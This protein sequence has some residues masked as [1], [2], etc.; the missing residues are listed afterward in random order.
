MS[1]IARPFLGQT[2][3]YSNIVFTLKIRKFD[4][5][6]AENVK[7]H[8]LSCVC[9]FLNAQ[10][11][12]AGCVSDQRFDRWQ[13]VEMHTLTLCRWVVIW[14]AIKVC[15]DL[16]FLGMWSLLRC[17]LLFY[18][19]WFCAW[20]MPLLFFQD[21]LTRR[22]SSAILTEMVEFNVDYIWIS[23]C[24]RP[25][26]SQNRDSPLMKRMNQKMKEDALAICL[27]TSLSAIQQTPPFTFGLVA[28]NVFVL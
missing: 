11:A 26:W 15:E 6:V 3:N 12:F 27:F 28:C 19:P 22:R 21:D 9:S 4:N 10:L 18:V 23:A 17:V 1:S 25:T 5:F 24:V 2:K 16:C 20:E 14:R 7:G 13:C 8:Y